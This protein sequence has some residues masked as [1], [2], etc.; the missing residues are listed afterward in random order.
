M[1][2]FDGVLHN[3]TEVRGGSPDRAGVADPARIILGAYARSDTAILSTLRGHYALV[4]W[5]GQARRLLFVRDPTGI[6]PFFYSE[7]GQELRISISTESLLDDPLIPRTVNRLALAGE[8]RHGY[9]P[10]LEESHFAAIRRL[11]PGHVLEI[12]NRVSRVRR[13]WDPV[14]PGKP[15]E[16]ADETELS[17]FEQVL[18]RAVDRCVDL[19]PAGVYLSGGVDSAAVALLAADGNARRGRPPGPLALSLVFPHPD[20]NEEAVQRLVAERL[21]LPQIVASF[22]EAVGPGG[23]LA[24]AIRLSS[25]WPWPVRNLFEPGFQYLGAEAKRRGCQVILTGGGG[26]EW[27]A[28]SPGYARDLVRRGDAAGLYRLWQARRRYLPLSPLSVLRSIVWRSGVRPLLRDAAARQAPQVLASYRRRGS[29]DGIPRWMAPDPQLRRQILEQGESEAPPATSESYLS[30]K[31][32]ILDHP[33]EAMVMEDQFAGG[34]HLG[35]RILQPLWDPDLVDLLYRT[36]PESLNRGNREK[37]LVRDLVAS[38]FPDMG[39][40]WVR[41][42]FMDGFFASVVRGEGPQAWHGLGGAPALAELGLVDSKAVRSFVD[43]CLSQSGASP[44]QL[45]SVW[46]I[47]RLEAWLQA[48]L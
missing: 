27:L 24:A 29:S 7:V 6:Q 4:I 18:Q 36:P 3:P 1:V 34:Q 31:R 22:D 13:Y 17:G 30:D 46:N 35:V 20:C 11:P 21:A 39:H 15:V 16:W 23:L 42:V 25:G 38:R 44:H 45:R 10:A 47:L 9:P 8:L 40:D 5:D 19:G 33:V 28:L 2:V 43:A 41:T 32:A 26:D 14:P 37:G 12:A 48:R